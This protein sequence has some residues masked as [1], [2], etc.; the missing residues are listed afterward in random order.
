MIEFKAVEGVGTLFKD[1]KIANATFAV[2]GVFIGAESGEPE[3]VALQVTIAGMPSEEFI[4][5]VGELTF[6]TLHQ[7]FPLLVTPNTASRQRLQEYLAN[8]VIEALHEDSVSATGI[9][10]DHNGLHKDKTG[11]WL[12]VEG[13][14]V[15]GA[16]PKRYA[17]TPELSKIKLL[18]SPIATPVL[19]VLS[20]L[21]AQPYSMLLL[22]A[23][24]LATMVRSAI[25]DAG[26]NF[27]A[28]AWLFGGQGKG[29]TTAAK[30]IAGI[31]TERGDPA[32][33][34]ALFHDLASTLVAV[35]DDLTTWRDLPVILDDV[36]FSASRASQERR[37]EL[38]GQIVREA[39]NASDIIKKGSR[40]EQIH[41]RCQAGV[42]LTSEFTL[43][44][45]SDVTRCIL[46]KIADR[47]NLPNE[48]S[49]ELIASAVRSR[50][51]AVYSGTKAY[52][53]YDRVLAAI[54]GSDNQQSA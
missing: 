27:Q 23:Y 26:V 21:I 15:L 18:D 11:A 13:E 53:R 19:K 44:N 4:L 36:C 34:P 37:T 47:L 20:L 50:I 28:V 30:R 40:G 39:A 22:L 48:L 41:K 3:T 49:P 9:S 33:R 6:K 17:V 12:T 51:P 46:M 43:A 32:H 10:F 8:L 14:E 54:S 31:V 5:S 25:M 35:R 42:I 16:E 2:T 24:T 38:A 52:I 29:K 1:K 45:E 7:R